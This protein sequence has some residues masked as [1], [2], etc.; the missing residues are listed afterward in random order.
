MIQ[1]A[2][3][4]FKDHATFEW[5]RAKSFGDKKNE[6]DESG[7]TDEVVDEI[8]RRSLHVFRD[9]RSSKEDAGESV[10]YPSDFVVRFVFVVQNLL[11]VKVFS[12]L[13][14]KE[15]GDHGNDR[16]RLRRFHSGT[17]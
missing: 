1:R 4:F 13:S 3:R 16:K 15:D 14:S 7:N 11:N 6:L 8:D 5:F 2:N 12:R 17:Q 9:E 10:L